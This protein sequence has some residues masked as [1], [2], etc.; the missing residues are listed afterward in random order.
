MRLA[1]APVSKTRAGVR[2]EV[3][4][5]AAQPAEPVPAR[6]G[7]A[8]HA[9]AGRHCAHGRVDSAGLS[10]PGAPGTVQ[11]GGGIRRPAARTAAPGL[12]GVSLRSGCPARPATGGALHRDLRPQTQVLP[13]PVVLRRRRHP[14]ARNGAGA[15]RGGVPGG[16]LGD[17]GRGAA[18][19]PADG[20]GILGAERLADRPGTARRAP[21]RDRGA[22]QRPRERAQPVRL[23]RGGG[24]AVTARH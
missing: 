21:R 4:E 17:R 10:H 8:A 7:P 23:P 24:V 1:S 9:A 19:L 5:S 22:A 2:H 13:V 6:D 11:R 18:G 15:F 14:P 12:R 20:A 3:S 16:R